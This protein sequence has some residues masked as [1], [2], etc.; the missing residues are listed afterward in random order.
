ML[1]RG[2]KLADAV[3][4]FSGSWAFIFWFAAAVVVWIALNSICVLFG[5]W[6]E[7]P[8][9]ALN[10]AL[11]V[12]STFQGPIILMSQNRQTE[13]DREAVRALDQRFEQVLE[14]LDD[15][16]RLLIRRP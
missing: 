2:Q 9:I 3:T 4:E 8:Y 1:T 10:L 13:N 12:I 5:V 7:Y 6:D 14:Q 15:L 11:T 16:H